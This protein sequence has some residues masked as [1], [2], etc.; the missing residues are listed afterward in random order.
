MLARE[1][2]PLLREDEP[3]IDALGK[4]GEAKVN[5]ALVLS[6]SHLVGLLSISDLARALEAPPRRRRVARRRT[7]PAR[8]AK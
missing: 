3:A 1:Q 6:D 2:V 4:L 5:R 8:E 7:Q